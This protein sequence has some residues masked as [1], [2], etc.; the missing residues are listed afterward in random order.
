MPRS[1]TTKGQHTRETAQLPWQYHGIITPIAF[2]CPKF[3]EASK[4]SSKNALN[5]Y[6]A[7]EG[8][9]HIIRFSGPALFCVS[10]VSLSQLDIEVME[11]SCQFA[12][13]SLLHFRSRVR[14]GELSLLRELRAP[15]IWR[16]SM[17]ESGDDS[18]PWGLGIPPVRNRE[19]PE[20]SAVME[21]WWLVWGHRE[22]G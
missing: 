13:P 21:R 10:A 17:T 3:R 15:T 8:V 1:L 12:L 9:I 11:G 18:T 5:S 6:S 7:K 16:R 19:H 14:R 4:F 22:V 2:P 20:V